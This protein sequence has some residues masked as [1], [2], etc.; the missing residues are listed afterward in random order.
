M[1]T[2]SVLLAGASLAHAYT[3]IDS[4][5]FMRKNIDPIVLPGEYRSHMHDFFGS[6][7]VTVSTNSSEQLRQG[8]HTNNNPNDFS[9]YCDS[10]FT[11]SPT[12]LC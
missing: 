2:L 10:S 11:P 9:I 6:D 5:F 8:C 3:N 12:D 7:A 4:G 1:A